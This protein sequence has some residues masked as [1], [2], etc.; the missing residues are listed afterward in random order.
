M[1]AFATAYGLTL[2][3]EVT[4]EK[5][6][7][8]TAIPK[9]LKKLDIRGA[10]VTI[11]ALGC[12]TKIVA[13]IREQGADYVLAVKDNPP[14]LHAAIV[15]FTDAAEANQYDGMD[16]DGYTKSERSHGRDETRTCYVF[17]DIAM[18]G[19][20][21]SWRDV[22][23]VIKVVS[24][25]VVEGNESQ[26]V[27]YYISSRTAS[28]EEMNRHIRSHWCIG[29]N[30]HWQLDVTYREDQSMLR[31]GHGPENAALLK[32]ITL[33]ILKNATV[34]KEK[35]ISGKRQFAGWDLDVMNSIL[36]QFL[37]I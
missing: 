29:N 20:A 37:E 3:Q 36:R 7:E 12:Q 24:N 10:V 25:R 27:R 32:K 9:L 19:L 31:E 28:A 2:S 1:T 5:S 4:D 35:W 21:K 15:S 26:E 11:D 30:L 23:A 33:S 22:K 17:R 13:A 34:G 16:C 14:K 6:N 8:I 18:M